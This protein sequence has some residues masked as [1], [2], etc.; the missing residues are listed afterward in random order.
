MRSPVLLP[1]CSNFLKRFIKQREIRFSL[2]DSK[3]LKGLR[4]FNFFPNY[5]LPLIP[6][7]PNQSLNLPSFIRSFLPSFFPSFPRGISTFQSFPPSAPTFL[8]STCLP[9]FYFCLPSLLPSFLNEQK[10][11]NSTLETTFFAIKYQSKS[12]TLFLFCALEW[13][14]RKMG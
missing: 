1:K 4:L 2:Q 14:F 11:I 3:R 12:T 9:P 13:I 7:S 5:F 10:M 8:L 6:P